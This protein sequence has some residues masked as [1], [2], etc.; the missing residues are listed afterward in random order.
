MICVLNE[1]ER[2]RLCPWIK[3]LEKVE[4]IEN[5]Q[6]IMLDWASYCRACKYYER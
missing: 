6:W 5:Q 1:E 4:S 2:Q 3:D